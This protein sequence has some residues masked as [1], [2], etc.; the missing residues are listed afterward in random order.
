MKLDVQRP[1]A[2]HGRDRVREC[3]SPVGVG[4]RGIPPEKL[5]DRRDVAWQRLRM[6]SG[7]RKADLVEEVAVLL[8]GMKARRT[9]N[10]KTEKVLEL[11]P[12][13]PVHRQKYKGGRSVRT[14]CNLIGHKSSS[15]GW[16]NVAGWTL[17]LGGQFSFLG[18]PRYL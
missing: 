14:N 7:R 3:L 6:W 8:A 2:A 4:N 12:V 1:R 18:M 15:R 11:G 13:G 9:Q 17:Q 16:A 5:L 10:R